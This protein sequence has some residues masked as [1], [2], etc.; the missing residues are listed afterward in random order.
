M[1]PM[2]DDYHN[3]HIAREMGLPLIIV[4]RPGLGTVNHTL[5]TIEKARAMGI[6][7]I[8]IIINGVLQG[9]KTLAEQTNRDLIERFTDVPVLGEVPWLENLENKAI[10][11]A[12]AE[13]VSLDSLTSLEV[14]S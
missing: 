7:V 12:V 4:A 14:K 1:A 11:K 5:L 8:G 2:G 10:I 9:E 3:G 6:E 13:N